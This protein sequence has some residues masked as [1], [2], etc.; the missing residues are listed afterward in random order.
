MGWVWGMGLLADFCLGVPN[1]SISRVR[2]APVGCMQS[3]TGSRRT[4][5]D[6]AGGLG[7]HWCLSSGHVVAQRLHPAVRLPATQVWLSAR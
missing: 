6:K 5:A 3:W 7:I 1:A 2:E 4:R